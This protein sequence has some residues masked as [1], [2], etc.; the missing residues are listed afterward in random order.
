MLSS[1]SSGIHVLFPPSILF[2]EAH[3]FST[4]AD[5]R[6][7]EQ[8]VNKNQSH[9]IISNRENESGGEGVFQEK[10]PKAVSE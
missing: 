5:S 2:L 9:G 7:D 8:K 10:N 4:L 1:Q 3:Q 6:P